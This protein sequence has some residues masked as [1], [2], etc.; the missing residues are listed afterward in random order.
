[1]FY[2]SYAARKVVRDRIQRVGTFHDH[3][4]AVWLRTDEWSGTDYRAPDMVLGAASYPTQETLRDFTVMQGEARA[5]V[6]VFT[7][8]GDLVESM[9]I[10]Q[11]DT[12]Q[13]LKAGAA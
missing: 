8:R 4:L 10:T 9:R 1:M 13:L 2:L 7:R 5:F 11:K 12:L 3:V 6:Q